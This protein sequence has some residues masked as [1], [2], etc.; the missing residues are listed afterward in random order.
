[1]TIAATSLAAALWDRYGRIDAIRRS[2]RKDAQQ[3]LLMCFC[4]DNVLS[5]WTPNR[6][7]ERNTV[8]A[9]VCAFT[10]DRLKTRCRANRHNLSLI[11]VQLKLVAIHPEQNII[12]TCLS[13]Y[14]IEKK[15]TDRVGHF[16]TAQCHR[17]TYD[18][19]NYGKKSQR[20]GVQGKQDRSQH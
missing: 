2:S 20:L 10:V 8:S 1:M 18:S 12:N 17:R 3:M 5:R 15:G 14:R 9:N 13:E 16:W 7:F 4:T 6:R 19:H 11:C